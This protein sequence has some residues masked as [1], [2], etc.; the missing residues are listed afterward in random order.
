MVPRMARGICP[1]CRH[2]P[3]NTRGAVHAVTLS[4]GESPAPPCPRLLRVLHSGPSVPKMPEHMPSFPFFLPC[5]P[6][7]PQ[8]PCLTDKLLCILQHPAPLISTT[9]ASVLVPQ[10][11]LMDPLISVWSHECHHS[12]HPARVQA[13]EGQGWGLAHLCAPWSGRTNGLQEQDL[14]R[15]GKATSPCT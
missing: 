13:P 2:A 12:V 6:V 10:A 4:P 7:L 9:K 3:P 14:P 11:K 1:K 8:H 15:A 5:L